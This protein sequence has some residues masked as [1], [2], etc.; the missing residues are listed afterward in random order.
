MKPEA[1]VELRGEFQPISTTVPGVQLCEH[2]PRLA[3]LVHHTTILRSVH[4]SVNNSHAAAVYAALTGHDRGEKGGGARPTD[5]PAIGSVVGKLFPPTA[6]MLPYVSLPYITKEGA[7][8]PPQPGFFGG[9]LGRTHDPYF[10]LSNPND[11]AFH[12]EDLSPAAGVSAERFAERQQLLR[13]FSGQRGFD[14]QPRCKTGM[15]SST[16]PSTC[17]PRRPRSA[18]STS[19]PSRPSCAPRTAATSTGRAC[20]WPG[21]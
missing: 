13:N 18:R 20:S 2:L 11:P 3:R 7:A 4:H 16:R 15:N 5:N 8:G 14:A 6:P 9:W 17:S 19:R 1:P 21:G 10:V 12:V